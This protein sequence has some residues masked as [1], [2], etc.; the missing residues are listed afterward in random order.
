[1]KKGV[2]T[3]TMQDQLKIIQKFKKI[4]SFVA[5]YDRGRKR[6]DLTVVEDV[7]TAVKEKSRAGVKSCRGLGIART[8]D[9]PVSML[10]K[11]LRNVPYCYPLSTM[12]T[13]K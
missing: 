8:L 13:V 4:G 12:D 3:I 10:H 9:R 6:I 1:M 11:I 5:Q 2:G 7:A